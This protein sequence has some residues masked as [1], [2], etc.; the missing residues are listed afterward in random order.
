MITY[1]TTLL[2]CFAVLFGSFT[3]VYGQSTGHSLE[4][5]TIV[6]NF[7][8][9]NLE[10]GL[11]KTKKS[12]LLNSQSNINWLSKNSKSFGAKTVS[13]I[14]LNGVLPGTDYSFSVNAGFVGALATFDNVI[15]STSGDVTSAT[16]TFSTSGTG[17]PVGVQDANEF[18]ILLTPAGGIDAFSQ[19][20]DPT[21]ATVI[22]RT[23]G[24][25][26]L[27]LNKTGAGTFQITDQLGNPI[28][29]ANLQS[30]LFEI[31]Y[32]H[33]STAGGGTE[34]DRFAIISVTDPNNTL[35]AT[36]TIT[37]N[38]FPAAVDDTNSILANAVTPASGDLVANDTDLTVG[39]V[40]TIS[41]VNGIPGAVGNSFASTYGSITV[42][43]DGTYDYFVDT[44][45]IAVSGLRSGAS[46]VDIISYAIQD[47]NGNIDFGYV[48][49]TING[50][51][52]L[53][54]AT[55]NTNSVTVGSAPTATG[56]I[57][58]DDNGFGV[59]TGDRPLAQFIWENQ[60]SAPGG[61]FVGFSAP[62]NGETR[63]EPTTGVTLSF[64]STD[65]D[66]IGVANQNQVV[67]QTGTNGGHFGYLL[68]T[69]DANTNPSQSTS[70]IIDFDEPVVN[71][72][73]TLSDI[74]WSQTD[75]WQDQMTVTGS[76]GGTDVSYIPQVSG[77]VV[78]V[79]VDTFYGT[80]SVPATDAHG[81]VGIYF[82]TP[83]DQVI[84]SY[85]YGPDATAADNG[86][87]IA[88]VF[89]LNWQGTGVPRI[90]AVDGNI[91]DVGVQIPTTYGFITINGDGTY[92][93]TVDASNPAVVSLLIGG[94]LTDTIPY[95][96]IDT[97]DNSGNVDS[98]N[99]V[100]TINGS[101][102]DSDGDM[103]VDSID[104][105][106]D[107]DGILDTIEC[108]FLNLLPVVVDGT[109]ESAPGDTETYNSNVALTGWSQLETGDTW[110]APVPVSGALTICD[111][112]PESPDGGNFAGLRDGFG[113]GINSPG[114]GE[115]IYTTITGL[116]T[117][118]SYT[119][120]F[121]QVFAG[122]TATT[123]P[124]PI[125]GSTTGQFK[126]EVGS[127]GTGATGTADDIFFSD[128]MTFEGFG[129]QT[130]QNQ[131]ITFTPLATSV[132]VRIRPQSMTPQ[133]E[134]LGIDGVVINQVITDLST[135]C[136]TDGDGIADSLDLDSDNDGIYDVLESGGIPNASIG[137]EGRHAD[138]DN[139]V[140][141]TATNGV[142]SFANGGAG[143]TPTNTVGTSPADF[144]NTDSDGD[145][146]SD[147]NEAYNDS[148]S[149]G[150]DGGIY[151]PGNTA[152]EPLNEGDGTVDSNGLVT[153]AA[154]NTGN[155]AAVVDAG[156][157][158]ACNPAI[159]TDED[160]V[161][162]VS[163]LDDDNDGIL[164]T[165]ECATYGPNLVVNE[166]LENVIGWNPPVSTSTFIFNEMDYGGALGN[167]IAGVDGWDVG[168]NTPEIRGGVDRV[169][170]NPR[171]GDYF[172]AILNT[173]EIGFT[174]PVT[175]S[176]VYQVDFYYADCATNR[177]NI[178]TGVAEFALPGTNGVV[179]N[180]SNVGATT[181]ITLPAGNPA[182]AGGVSP[183]SWVQGSFIFTS[184]AA[185]TDE[186]ITFSSATTAGFVCIDLVTVREVIVGGACPDTDGDGITNDLD[187]D[188][189]NDGIYD[190]IEAGGTASTT[191]G[192]EGRQDDDDDN[193]DNT[194]TFGVPS[195][196][197]PA[198][199]TP[200]QT[201][202]GT[203]DYL[204]VDSDGDGCSDANEAYVDPD[205]DGGDG[206]VYNPGNT[207]T[208]PLNE[209]D[210]TVDANGVVTA[211]AYNT[212]VVAG[213]TNDTIISGCDD[214]DGVAASIEDAGP[215]G[216]D[217]NGDGI[218]DSQQPNV[219]SLP[220]ATG[221]GEYITL[222][223]T[224]PCSQIASI[225]ALLESD[226]AFQEVY[227]YPVG[228]ID[229][230]LSCGAP[231]QSAII[232]YF[233]HGLTDYNGLSYRKFG[234][235]IPGTGTAIYQSYVASNSTQLIGAENV[236]SLNYILTDGVF[237]D[238][239]IV[240]SAIIDPSGPASLPSGDAD[241]DNVPDNVDLDDDNDGIL[242]TAE[243]DCP[244]TNRIINEPGYAENV[245]FSGNPSIDDLAPYKT[246][247]FDFT[248]ALT[249]TST[250]AN[251][252]RLRSNQDGVAES[253]L[254]F[255]P[256]NTDFGNNSTAVYTLTFNE[257]VSNL[258]FKFGGLD[259]SD[260]ARFEAF[261]NGIPVTVDASN[262]SAFSNANVSLASSTEVI[263]VGPG[264]GDFT[265]NEVLF[266]IGEPVDQ[267]V[268]TTGK[269]NGNSGTVTL[270]IYEL[271][272]CL[273]DFDGDGIANQFDL[274]SDDD[275]IYDVVETGGTD[276]NDDGQADDLDGDGSNNNGIPNTAGSGISN[277][278]DT[279]S[280]VNDG[281][282]FLDIDAD[283]DGI[284]DNIEGQTT[285]GYIAPIV[286]D[287]LTPLVDE[288]D[289]DGNGVNDAY[290]TNGTVLDPSLADIDGTGGAD[291]I[292]TDAD[293]DGIPDATEGYDTDG[294]NVPD[295]LPAGTDADGDGLDDNYDATDLAVD[296]NNN[297]S[298][299]GE[300]ATDFPD[301]DNVGGDRDWRD[302]IDA[303]E[304]G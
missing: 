229:F 221:S 61:V 263:G 86:G 4:L 25:N 281:P 268:I 191:P 106:D 48:T 217:G 242:D 12:T 113:A 284:Q 37:F 201:T 171:D 98:A 180:Y 81:N 230:E 295:T 7:S 234:R 56:N 99:L 90:S 79:G 178:D 204:N 179:V 149:D 2:W 209:S 6:P 257:L 232:T 164:D 26:I 288:S 21:P 23:Y 142:P 267:I 292:D 246:A 256:R 112:T 181:S 33:N 16:I 251:G 241:G 293:G 136:D 42:L 45:N 168:V 205:A 160:G 175:A 117:T 298:D 285:G 272:Y 101:A 119:I 131:S 123:A 198:G 222:Q 28:L 20:N 104:L 140:D 186:Q 66:A 15:S 247:D 261:R 137:Q 94:T 89:D 289:T 9:H 102:V 70:L 208:E 206:G 185:G 275:G 138:N 93:Y 53:P 145:N 274:D 271:N 60:F 276:N 184:N 202:S 69:I 253:H 254:Y 85:N 84:F 193:A 18:L 211:A 301:D 64:T 132:W 133:A 39:D 17:A 195:T 1:S 80:G 95:T 238:D 114:G 92:T 120:N 237:G 74:D 125:V 19:I 218:P 213:V 97:V 302:P 100:I 303:D 197:A 130:W 153:A 165:V 159:D 52:E 55:N 24:S 216:G 5:G 270:G 294:D 11:I 72:S 245:D 174:I 262:F 155:V 148:N 282:N 194:A 231:G 214:G 255:Q 134:Y 200:I 250:W 151:N 105:D 152:T 189:D 279:D 44:G 147:A 226:L 103:V 91:G 290:D 283:D 269:N 31:F 227:E 3:A 173:E 121:S 141:N 128:A 88:G 144:I 30:F 116:S 161:D 96:L 158:S 82:D 192:Q 215:N 54:V 244:S 264:N 40:L 109:F 176:T 304:D 10:Q 75:S 207:S 291:Y 286:D 73:T 233:F 166:S 13:S 50:V 278:T 43:A 300:V 36:T 115:A 68:F 183:G 27:V 38:Y 240:D 78:Q 219:A 249:G 212:G 235:E 62:I 252:V 162:D 35:S 287:P 126:V 46:L 63:V 110:A 143:N 118:E 266:T 65:P 129:S 239:N 157:D 182:V 190:V 154:Y 124:A 41:E 58:F 248:Y 170:T 188:S 29:N 139:N 127:V 8:D 273:A 135:I 122:T 83:V 296:P 77:S 67:A 225:S 172:G 297:A 156:D 146:C 49:I 76:L 71:L 210:N 163:D 299:G 260:I 280:N 265:V 169:V 228:L 111:G 32:L 59:D 243:A 223:I 236:V 87:Q 51:D 203:P 177:T 220:D 187:L 57:I 199:T 107:N 224:G 167:F 150:G 22:T 47:I 108:P 259:N 14:D 196:V 34:G 277:P 258:T